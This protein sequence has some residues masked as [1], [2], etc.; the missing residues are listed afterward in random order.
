[1]KSVYKLL[2][3]FWDCMKYHLRLF[4]RICVTMAVSWWS[5]SKCG[6]WCITANTDP[7]SSPS[8]HRP[9]LL[10]RDPI[11]GTP[12][13]HCQGWLENHLILLTLPHIPC[14]ANTTLSPSLQPPPPSRLPDSLIWAILQ[15]PSASPLAQHPLPTSNP[16][17]TC[18]LDWFFYT[19]Y[20]R[21]SLPG[22]K[23]LNERPH[24]VGFYL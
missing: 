11:S 16:G 15:L 12:P 9:D 14:P 5:H 23:H 10:L 18:H 1:M 3:S 6:Q 20:L 19:A 2:W 22:L 17:Y 7:S 24:V 8:H 13:T 4:L 21:V